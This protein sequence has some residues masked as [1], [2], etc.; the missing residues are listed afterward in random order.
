M[1]LEEELVTDEPVVRWYPQFS[2]SVFPR[3]LAV[4]RAP[5]AIVHGGRQQLDFPGEASCEVEHRTED[6][7]VRIL[8]I[9]FLAHNEW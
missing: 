4:I 8:D 2:L 7:L 5:A 3:V 9:E 6:S 1:R